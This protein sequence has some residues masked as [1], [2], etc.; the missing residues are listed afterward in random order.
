MNDLHGHKNECFIE[1]VW[2]RVTYKM[3]YND[4]SSWSV[5][6]LDQLEGSWPRYDWKYDLRWTPLLQNEHFPNL[7]VK[8]HINWKLMAKVNY[9]DQ[10]EV[11]RPHNDQKCDLRWTSWKQQWLF[12]THD[13]WHINWKVTPLFY[14]LMFLTNVT[15]KN[16]MT[17]WGPMGIEGQL[18]RVW[19]RKRSNTLEFLALAKNMAKIWPWSIKKNEGS[20]HPNH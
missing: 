9:L 14:L 13:K 3:K 19:G 18:P 7:D 4:S 16:T 5:N 11:I 1:N 6:I 15:S 8:W 2:C 10:L 17:F 12:L 20:P